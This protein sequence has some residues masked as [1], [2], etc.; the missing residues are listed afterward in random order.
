MGTKLH[1]PK[2]MKLIFR[3]FITINGQRVWAKQRG[4]KAFPLIVPDDR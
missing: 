3:P 1:V 4:L 2:G